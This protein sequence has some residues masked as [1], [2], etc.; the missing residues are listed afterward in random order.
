MLCHSI[1]L[2]NYI[3][4]YFGQKDTFRAANALDF[5]TDRPRKGIR[6]ARRTVLICSAKK[7][8]KSTAPYRQP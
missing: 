8:Y 2:H 1:L 6:V 7:K 3:D 4:F 5:V